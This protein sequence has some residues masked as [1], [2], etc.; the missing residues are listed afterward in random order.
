M[1][2]TEK[3]RDPGHIVESARFGQAKKKKSQ[4]R[5]EAGKGVEDRHEASDVRGLY[6]L[7]SSNSV[8]EL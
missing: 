6:P 1:E 7:S 4:P 8:V 3:L 2:S 5:D